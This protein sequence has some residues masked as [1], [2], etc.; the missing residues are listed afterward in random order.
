MSEQSTNIQEREHE[1]IYQ[2]YRRLPVVIDKAEGC[3][4]TDIDGNVY[5]DFLSGIAVN[6][7]GHSHPAILEAIET[8]AKKYLHVSNFFYQEPQVELAEALKAEGGFDKVFFT[9]SG[10]EAWEGAIK[11]ARKY[12]NARGKTGN[13]I[14]FSGG[15]HGRTYAALSSMDKPLYKNG[16]EPFLPNNIVLPFNDVEVLRNAV[17]ETTCAVG[18]E[19]L[20]GEGGITYATEEF[21]REIVS[22]QQQF[23]FVLI[24]DEVQAG[25]GRTGRFFSY[26]KFGVQPHIVT[27]AKGIGGG[28]PLGAVGVSKELSEIFEKGNHGTTYGGNALACAT[29]LAVVR[30]LNNNVMLNVQEVGAY[31][32]TQLRLLQ[33]EFPDYVREVRGEGMMQGIVVEGESAPLNAALLTQR[34]V[35][36][37]TATNV[38]R[39]V[40]PLTIS[41]TDV[42]EF[43]VALR[44]AIRI[45]LQ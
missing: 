1:A 24:A 3:R 35:A 44:N 9:N 37:A 27:M 21:V 22:L 26:Q 43:I 7:L 25:A 28:L 20:Q 13:I 29:G 17:N 6:A 8:Q 5:L 15:F 33:E 18:L 36:N 34:V 39:L 30:E 4:I 12:G 45:V 2:L 23:G 40:P 38:L 42:D 32:H 16:M 31:L 19:F 14:C 11:L 10:T 41:T